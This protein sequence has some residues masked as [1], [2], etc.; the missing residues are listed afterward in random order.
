MSNSF[1]A[2]AQKKLMDITLH[3]GIGVVLSVLGFLGTFYFLMILAYFF[4]QIF[5]QK[6]KTYFVLAGAAYI[7]SAEV[8]LRMTS[9]IPFWEMGKY[10]VILFMLVGMFYKGF[11]LQAW[12]ILI[13]IMLLLPGVYISY[14]NNDFI[15]ESFR[16]TI[17]F[18]L[19]GPLSLFATA[20]FC[21]QRKVKFKE[22]MKLVDVMILPI[23]SMTIYIILYSPSLEEVVFTTDSNAVTSG[24]FSGNQVSTV[25]GF[26]MFL[27]YVRFLIPHRFILLRL[28]NIVFLGLFTYRA[29]LTFSRGGV[30][31][32][33]LM[34]LVFTLLYFN[35]APLVAKAK[36]T[37]KLAGVGFGGFLLWGVA[38]AATGGL[39]FNRYTGKN[40]IGEEKD[41]T[42][43]R[44]DILAEELAAFLENP[45]F[46]VGVGLGKLFRFEQTGISAASHNEVS[47]MLGE[48]GS[49][50]ILALLILLSVPVGF[51]LF[52]AKN[53]FLVPLV[54]F[55]F[56]TINH[57][58]MR[59]ALPGFLY[60]LAL[61]QLTYPSKKEKAKVTK[62][63]I[64]KKPRVGVLAN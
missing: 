4:I 43:G 50:G 18:N 61:L 29:L 37:I 20:L 30:V 38:M 32:A 54:A 49:L 42:T 25:L 62:K 59:V 63:S 10:M 39:I 1:D 34:M 6:D 55:W 31:T 40:I 46:G 23:I 35:W 52:K 58:S 44:L 24:G 22:M 26:G 47:R 11:K 53:L 36:A 16:K 3:V 21:Y 51:F 2:T 60:G 28:L 33:V 17:L 64:K 8:F 9:A 56:L 19:S 5:K 12:P 27:A 48:H 7:A 45:V 13:F 15:D 41:I 57:S 14:L